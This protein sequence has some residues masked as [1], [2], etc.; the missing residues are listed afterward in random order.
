MKKRI[1]I[2]LLAVLLTLT[3]SPIAYA[4]GE[5]YPFTDVPE[6]RWYYSCVTQLYQ[7]GV[8]DGYGDGTFRPGGSVTWGEAFKLVLLSIGCKEP[9][10]VP[11][12]H[13]A[14]PY[15]QL[16]IS[17]RMF[18]EFDSA[19]LDTA[20]TRLALAQATARALGLTSISGESPYA[21]CDDG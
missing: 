10:H 7:Q 15:I 8:I 1:A 4:D 3:G 16:A 18:D 11:G 5:A 9:E 12:K 20:P 21:D 17:N 14:Y 13:W 6:S 2:L 19:L